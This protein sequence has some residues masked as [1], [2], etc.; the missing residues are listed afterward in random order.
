MIKDG[1]GSQNQITAKPSKYPQGWFKDK[2]CKWCSGSFK[3]RGPSHHYCSD[4]CK[5]KGHSDK[6]Y[7]RNYGISLDEMFALMEG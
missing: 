2:N 6:Y 4:E 1:N 3:P 7:K 5:A